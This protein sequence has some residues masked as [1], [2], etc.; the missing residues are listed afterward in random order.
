MNIQLTQN[1]IKPA[2]IGHLQAGVFEQLIEM[3]KETPGDDIAVTTIEEYRD[4]VFRVEGGSRV[5][6]ALVPFSKI[7][8]AVAIGFQNWGAQ[9]INIRQQAL[10][11]HLDPTR[12]SFDSAV[13]FHQDHPSLGLLADGQK[14][15]VR[16]LCAS[17]LP[18]QLLDLTPL[19]DLEAFTKLL[20]PTHQNRW[21]HGPDF[22]DTK[23]EN[24]ARSN[25]GFIRPKAGGVV[26]F[27]GSTIHRAFSASHAHIRALL[28]IDIQMVM[29]RDAT[30]RIKYGQ[31]PR[32]FFAG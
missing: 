12:A 22:D 14:F 13:D 1:G 27:D 8:D 7:G 32:F 4:T 29:P 17:S 6:K 23:I 26:V 30:Y 16:L 2:I 10:L 28:N 31:R 24:F 9:I 25:G 11:L 5:W 19:K 21:R 18:T 15:C 20:R 3:A